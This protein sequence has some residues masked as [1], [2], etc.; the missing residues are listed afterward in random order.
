MIHIW[1]RRLLKM[2]LSKR[3]DYSME[4][5]NQGAAIIWGNTVLLLLHFKTKFQHT[6][7]VM[8]DSKGVNG[9][10]YWASE[11]CSWVTWRTSE[12]F[13]GIQITQ[14]QYCNQSC[15]LKFFGLV[16]AGYSLPKQQIIIIKLTFF[17]PW[18]WKFLS[19]F[20]WP[21][22]GVR[23]LKPYLFYRECTRNSTLANISAQQLLSKKAGLQI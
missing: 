15:S 23:R 7:E 4:A 5:I 8:S 10:C 2:Y 11:F 3:G 22:L 6:K 13:W 12:V 9:F 16:D 18:I 17:E 20:L 14:K 21:L 1:G 19:P